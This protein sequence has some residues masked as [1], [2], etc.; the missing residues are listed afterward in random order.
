[1]I[2]GMNTQV[3]TL[4]H[5]ILSLAGIVAGLILILALAVNKF[6]RGLHAFFVFTTALTSITGF[7]FPFHGVTP[8]IVLG[9]L[10]IIVLLLA[11]CALYGGKLKGGWRGT[12]VI[13]VALAEWFNVFVLF[14]QLFAKVPT[15][16]AIAPMQ[17]SPAF[18]ATQLVV[19][20]VFIV[21][22]IRSFKGF[23]GSAGI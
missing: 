16:K 14:A 7:L 12:Y 11:E 20:V 13:S 6:S 15:L 21:L 8:G 22:T 4:V 19:L 3:F 10:S 1:M 5:V 9:V 2:L 17:S 23:R 18:G